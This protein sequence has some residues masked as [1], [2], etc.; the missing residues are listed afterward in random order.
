MRILFPPVVTGLLYCAMGLDVGLM[1][2]LLD[3][4]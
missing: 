2:R 3:Q 4:G 1:P